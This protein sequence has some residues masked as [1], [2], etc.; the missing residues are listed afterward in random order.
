M[1][2][3]PALALAPCN[4]QLLYLDAKHELEDSV[5]ETLKLLDQQ[6]DCITHNLLSNC[7]IL[8]LMLTYSS[9]TRCQISS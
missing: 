9:S 1:L 8:L 6:L 2:H 5:I 3:Y 7:L 4:K